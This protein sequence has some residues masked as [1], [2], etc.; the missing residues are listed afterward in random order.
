MRVEDRR[1][2]KP[3]A[4]LLLMSSGVTSKRLCLSCRL[5]I[6]FLKYG[7]RQVREPESLKLTS[8][9]YQ[10]TVV[11]K[12]QIEYCQQS[13]HKVYL[14]TVRMSSGLENRLSIF[15]RITTLPSI[16]FRTTA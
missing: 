13:F 9:Q 12:R 3:G 16:S 1:E 6:F 5:I 4:S 11:Y 14:E 15:H 7:N 8:V 10:L 2:V